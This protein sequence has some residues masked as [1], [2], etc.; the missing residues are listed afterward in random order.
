MG[1]YW[2]T[3]QAMAW[4]N[5]V[6]ACEDF[7]D[8][9]NVINCVWGAVST[10]I[11]AAGAFWGGIQTYGRVQTWAKNNGISFGGFKR[12]LVDAELIDD[13]SGILPFPVSHLGVFDYASLGLNG[14]LSVRES[15][16]PID[17][18]EFTGPSGQKMHFSFLGHMENMGGSN[19]KQIAF[20]FGFGTGLAPTTVK[21]RALFDQQYFTSGGIDFIPDENAGDGGVLS[22]Q[23]DCGQMDHE[24]SCY[25]S[26]YSDAAGTPTSRSTIITM[27]ALLLGGV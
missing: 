11:T 17:V 15:K 3:A 5:M 20:K 8:T 13:L 26:G 22:T 1:G 27:M 9:S 7:S 16:E 10:C 25:M 23:W 4:W 2:M 18:F 21:G 12:D 19:K 24:V 14:T 6:A